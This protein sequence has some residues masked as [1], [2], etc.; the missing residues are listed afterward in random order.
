MF[1]Y[2][3]HFEDNSKEVITVPAGQSQFL[4][5]PIITVKC[6]GQV[7]ITI[8][9]VLNDNTCL[10]DILR[11][12]SNTSLPTSILGQ[13][14][15]ATGQSFVFRTVDKYV[16]PG[17]YIYTFVLSN[18]SSSDLIIP[19]YSLS[20][21]TYSECRLVAKQNYSLTTSS[22]D[23]TLFAPKNGNTVLYILTSGSGTYQISNSKG[24]VSEGETRSYLFIPQS[25]AINERYTLRITGK[26]LLVSF[27][28]ETPECIS[29]EPIPG[30]VE[31]SYMTEPRHQ[32][33]TLSPPNEKKPEG[34]NVITDGSYIYITNNACK[35]NVY[36]E[37]NIKI[38]FKQV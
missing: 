8:S 19:N 34:I 32:V 22:V 6:I 16:E 5:T 1:Y 21:K 35:I 37:M 9:F 15:Q 27:I 17:N 12:P 38:M 36:P 3:Q 26:N 20:V 7:L 23:Y 24:I 30:K 2:R 11:S 14:V 10:V 33:V 25:C 31:V 18:Q 13:S 4:Y 29:D 28:I